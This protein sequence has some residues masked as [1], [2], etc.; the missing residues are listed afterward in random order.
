MYGTPIVC[1]SINLLILTVMKSV[2]SKLLFLSTQ[3]SY[4]L[5]NCL[6]VALFHRS[7]SGQYAKA[8]NL[9][10]F[11]DK[12]MKVVTTVAYMDIGLSVM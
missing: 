4:V 6:L 8:L 9:L 2:I 5:L 11:V 12:V 10:F 3:P 7:Q 1:F